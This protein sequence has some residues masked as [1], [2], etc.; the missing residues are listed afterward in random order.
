M[1]GTHS[2][3]AA[4]DYGA[5]DCDQKKLYTG[6]AAT[7]GPYPMASFTSVVGEVKNFSACHRIRL[8]KVYG[9]LCLI[10]ISMWRFSD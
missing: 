4:D 1:S 3:D 5:L 10:V 9:A 2:Y 8:P 7:P 6:V